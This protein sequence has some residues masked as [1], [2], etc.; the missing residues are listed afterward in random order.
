MSNAYTIQTSG[1]TPGVSMIKAGLLSSLLFGAAA[2]AMPQVVVTPKYELRACN[3]TP[4]VA[5]KFF[6]VD[7]LTQAEQMLDFESSVSSFYAKLEA[8]QEAL[9]Q[10]FEKVLIDN[11]WD[12]YSR[13]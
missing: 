10:Q 12:L 5:N 1:A 11:L 9:G 8:N 6:F 7:T 2:D 3:E 4:S 13:S